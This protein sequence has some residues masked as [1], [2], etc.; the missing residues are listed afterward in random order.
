VNVKIG[1]NRM[2]NCL[3]DPRG[4]NNANLTGWLQRCAVLG[5]E[6][7]QKELF[8][9]ATNNVLEIIFRQQNLDFHQRHRDIHVSI[10][11]NSLIIQF[12]HFNH[13]WNVDNSTG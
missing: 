13:I 6:K 2:K 9:T 12:I 4:P 11:S 10:F 1:G 8:C 7:K 3:S 5:H